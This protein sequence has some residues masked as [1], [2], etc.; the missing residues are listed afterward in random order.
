MGRYLLSNNESRP[1][2]GAVWE[3]GKQSLN[4]H[5]SIAHMI[6]QR[7]TTRQS[8]REAGSF[9]ELVSRLGQGEWVV[10]EREEFQKFYQSLSSFA[11]RKIMD[12]VR[13]VWLLKGAAVDR[14]FCEGTESGAGIYFIDARNKVLTQIDLN[15]DTLAGLEQGMTSQKGFLED[16]EG[17]PGRI[18]GADTFFQGAFQLPPS[19]I[20]DL[21]QDPDLL[22]DQKG[23]I[24]R[25]GIW[26]QAENGNI[27]LGFELADQG[28]TR[29]LFVHAREWA[30]WQLGLILK[31]EIQ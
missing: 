20:P 15:P 30:V 2:K 14:I 9:T 27:R 13:L 4:A 18:Y 26:N 28:E 5:R 24:Q 23:I 12:P 6:D 17:F 21:M 29:V 19:M 7:E 22:L 10:I 31:G 11:A 25:V 16:F 8:I 3:A 1:E